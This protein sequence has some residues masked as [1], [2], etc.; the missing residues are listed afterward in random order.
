MGMGAE[1][2]FLVRL[3][4]S[5][6]GRG[7]VVLGPGPGFWNWPGPPSCGPAVVRG[8]GPGPSLLFKVL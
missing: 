8:P 7:S 1:I 6:G 3:R 2:Q 5:V 4:S